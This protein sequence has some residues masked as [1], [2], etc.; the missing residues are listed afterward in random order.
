VR[1]GAPLLAVVS[2]PMNVALLFAQRHSFRPGEIWRLTLATVFAVPL[3]ILAVRFLDERIVLA[4]LGLVL[5]GYSAY[6]LLGPRL[7]A[8]AHPGWAYLF[9]FFS[10][11]L[12]GAYNTG[13]PPAVIY[14]ACRNWAPGEFRSN[15]QALFLV[16]NV[17]VLAGHAATGN[18]TAEVSSQLWVA[19]PALIAGM[20]VGLGT[21]RFIPR[22]GFRKLVLVMLIALGIKLV[23]F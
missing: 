11:I 1:V 13:G 9:G 22:A 10:G 15:L 23:A 20:G 8:L 5:I 16:T 3:G 12:G 21:A 6:A 17:F 14:G 2:L 4:A 7:P 18:F 19:V